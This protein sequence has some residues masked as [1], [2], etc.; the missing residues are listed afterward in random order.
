M[1][2]RPV[3]LCLHTGGAEVDFG[4]LSAVRTP[5]A[6]ETWFPIAHDDLVN[7][8]RVGLGNANLEVVSESHALAKKGMRYFGLFQIA[9]PGI[10]IED[11]SLVMGLRNSHDKTF[12]AG[13]TAGS[14]V[15]VCDNLSFSGEVR[16]ARKH[17][18][19]I[20]RDLPGKISEAVGMLSNLWVTQ[21]RR[22]EAYKATRL[23]ST[24]DVHDLLIRAMDNGAATVTQL[25]HVLNE[26]RKPAHE[27]FQP[28]NV[29]SLFNA[30]TEVSKGSGLDALPGRTMK[31]HGLL[32]GYCGI[33]EKPVEV[34]A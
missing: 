34:T 13:I 6:T 14:Q 12:P 25:K 24:K 3:K 26:W 30:F 19:N 21:D 33:V 15:F 11:Y 5:E 2:T 4:A 8:V 10:S 29:W 32:D 31:L 28:R 27:E 17:T 1:N 22:F 16:L 20:F 9:K 23:E 7:R 18:L